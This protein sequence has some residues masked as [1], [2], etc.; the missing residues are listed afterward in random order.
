MSD[1]ILTEQDQWSIT[2]AL[3]LEQAGHL[4]AARWLRDQIK[5]L[6]G[7]DWEELK[8]THIAVQDLFRIHHGSLPPIT[9]SIRPDQTT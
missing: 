5:P 1:I 2:L 7:V 6:K 8:K 9:P 3:R 4:L